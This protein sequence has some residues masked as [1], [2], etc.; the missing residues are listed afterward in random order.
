MD[1]GHF[2]AFLPAW[3]SHSCLPLSLESGAGCFPSCRVGQTHSLPFC[4]WAT[5]YGHEGQSRCEKEPLRLRLWWGSI[6]C[7]S[8][9]PGLGRWSFHTTASL[10]VG[11]SFRTWTPRSFESMWWMH[12]CIDQTSVSTLVRKSFGGKES[13]PMLT[14]REKSLLPE[15]FSPEEDWTHDAASSRTVSPTQYQWAIP[16]PWRSQSLSH[17]NYRPVSNILFLSKETE[18]IFFNFINESLKVQPEKYYPRLFHCSLHNK[19]YSDREIKKWENTHKTSKHAGKYP[20]MSACQKLLEI[21]VH[22]DEVPAYCWTTCTPDFV[23][24]L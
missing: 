14:P 23:M 2:P 16:I 22:C 8:P 17:R 20:N 6:V 5:C 3:V 19:S 1:W 11:V 4:L 21:N 10:Y 15:H 24:F 9:S 7:L 13:E 18:E 12:V